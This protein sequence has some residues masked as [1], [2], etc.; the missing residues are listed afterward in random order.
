M[1]SQNI[2]AKQ[3]DIKETYLHEDDRLHLFTLQSRCNFLHINFYANRGK[4]EASAKCESHTIDGRNV[5]KL[6]LWHFSHHMQLVFCTCLV[7]TSVCLKCAKNRVCSA[8]Y[9]CQSS[10]AHSF[11]YHVTGDCVY[12]H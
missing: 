6:I 8:G 2:S 1:L 12:S 9:I 4:S 5:K 7:F 11:Q 10:S 3:R